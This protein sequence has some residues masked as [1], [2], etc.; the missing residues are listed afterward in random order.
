MKSAVFAALVVFG[1]SQIAAPATGL[2]QA[3][4]SL[5]VASAESAANERRA[6]VDELLSKMTLEE[7][8]GQLTLFTADQQVTGPGGKTP[9][10]DGIRAGRV[11]AVFNAFGAETTRE[12]QAI[13]VNESRLK[14][15]LLIGLDVIHGHRTIF[16][17]SLGEAA[18]WDLEA[19]ER[20]ARIAAIE[21]SAEGIN[22][23]FAPMVDIAR[24]PRWG[25]I[26]EG[27]GEDPYLGSL[28]AAA[29]VRG[30]QGAD[31]AAPD[32]ILATAKHFAAYGAA[33]AGRDYHT[34]DMSERTLREIYLPPFKAAVEAGVATVMSAFNDLNGAPATG[35]KYL[36]TDVLRNEWGFEGFVVSDYTSVNEMIAHGFARDEAD[37]GDIAINAGL[38]MDMQDGAYAEHLAASVAAGRVEGAIIDG[39]ARAVLEMKYR[40]GLFDDPYRYSDPIREKAMAKKPEHLEAARDVARKSMVLLKNAGGVLPLKDGL[41][42]IALIGPLGDSKTDMIGSWAG[43]GDRTSEPVTVLEGLRR[44]AGEGVSIRFVKGAGYDFTDK[45]DRSDFAE[46]IAAAREADVVI[47][48]MGERWDMTGEAASRTSLDLPGAQEDLLK[49]LKATGKPIILVLMNGRPL[50]IG[51]AAENADAILEAWYPG[52]LGG[53]AVADILFGDFNPSGKLPVTFPRTV[54]Q[55]PIFYNAKNTGR[56]YSPESA[57]QKYISR[58]LET[59]NTPLYPFG[60]GLSYTEFEYSPV[61]LNRSKLAPGGSLTASVTVRN[62]GK[63]EGIETVQFYIRDLVGSVTRPVKELKG[64]Q[65]VSLKPGER[66]MVSFTITEDD[67]A[68]YR[69]DMSY[70][71][72]PG[73][74]SV[75]IGGSSEDTV[76]A[77]F[78]L[79]GAN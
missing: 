64:Y 19:I 2:A 9:F 60:F 63:R 40:L 28:I 47:A 76:G 44:R 42:S 37:A 68:F 12:L 55:V 24:D 72:E 26:S 51:W 3:A 31:L 32:T 6:F 41:K 53:H 5:E 11:G 69:A 59:P 58:Y 39:A 54:G 20:S 77:K 75:M 62:T 22:W 52:T 78:V 17:I 48:A 7:K 45:A 56:P 38:D 66:K 27:A 25:R 4:P 73:E 49:E 15:P 8:I 21:A 70:G 65:R 13:A 35:N 14:I 1:W 33:Q 16:P 10:R 29:R 74:F 46:A 71:S 61:R 36:L 23:T 18:S 50:S 43:A 30:F 79:T 57:E 34:T 67:L